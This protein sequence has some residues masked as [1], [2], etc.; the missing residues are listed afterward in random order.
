MY[1]KTDKP[2]FAPRFKYHSI[3]FFCLATFVLVFPIPAQTFQSGFLFVYPEPADANVKVLEIESGY[4]PGMSLYPGTYLVQVEKPGYEKYEERIYIESKEMFDLFVELKRSAY[5]ADPETGMEF[6]WIPSGCFE[7]G[8]GQWADECE[9]DEVPRHNV[10]V[11]GFWLGKYEVT[12]GIWKKIMGNNPSRFQKGDNYPVEHVSWKQAREF[13]KK[14]KIDG[15]YTVRL[16]TEAEWE[17]AARGGGRQE[18][19]AGGNDLSILGWYEN[20]SEGSTHPVGTKVPNAFGLHD[21][22]GN[23]WEWCRDVYLQDAY[24]KSMENR[25]TDTTQSVFRVRRG[26]SW[27]SESRHLRNLFRG[28]YPSDLQFESNGLRVVL[29][30]N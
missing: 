26:G 24:S 29:E 10:C 16:P 13:V 9:P 17:Y 30:E 2:L 15:G 14:L 1:N 20:N 5:W 7:M 12:Q 18:V 27:D 25:H 6:I 28:S 3:I 23:V 22:N 4:S 11:H 19:Y 8:C 21:M